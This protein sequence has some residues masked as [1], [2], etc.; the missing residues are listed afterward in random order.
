MQIPGFDKRKNEYRPMKGFQNRDRI[1]IQKALIGWYRHAR[2]QLPWRQTDDPY[3]IWVSEVMLQQTR[4]ETVLGYYQ[5]FLNRF[6]DIQILAASDMDSV[7]KSWEGMGYYAR[8]RNLYLAAKIVVTEKENRIP[9]TWK[10]FRQLPG[11]GDYI[12]AAVLSIAFHQA[13]AVVD[14]NVKRVLARLAMNETAVN[15]S[16]AHRVY[17]K[18]AQW[19]LDINHPGTFNQALME[20]GALICIPATPRCGQCPIVAFCKARKTESISRYPL[21]RRSKP[22]PV[23]HYVAGI[24][25]KNRTVLLA[26]RTEDGLLGG[27][28]EFPG[29]EVPKGVNAADACRN[30]IREKM[31]IEI[32]VDGKA[33]T[34]RHAYTHFRIILEVFY[35]RYTSGRI[36]RRSH[37]AHRWIQPEKLPD[38]PLP[39]THHHLIPLVEDF[40]LR[41]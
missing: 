21:R 17:Q 20:L 29:G 34:I 26:R 37:S 12:A 14:G 38:Y 6:P 36:H 9:S 31:N 8:A 2:R 18:D 41:C 25:E 30:H 13:Y 15:E 35:C 27:L 1:A 23:R 3:R 28:W 19:L 11:V 33:A 22:V 32:S 39:K 24:V 16:F 40:V 4:V 7:L 5:P 10:E